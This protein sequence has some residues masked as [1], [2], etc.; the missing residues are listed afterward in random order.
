MFYSFQSTPLS[1]IWLHLFLGILFLNG[2]LNR[3]VFLIIIKIIHC[4]HIETQFILYPKTDFIT[5]EALLHIL[6]NYLHPNCECFSGR[7]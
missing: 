7:G 4:W 6:G 1:Y 3:I 5:L 2:I